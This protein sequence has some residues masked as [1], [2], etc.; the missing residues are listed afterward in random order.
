MSDSAANGRE[1]G[2]LP[3]G[4]PEIPNY[5]LV[6]LIAR[7]SYGEVW[8]ARDLI[9]TYRAVKIVYRSTFPDERPFKR[10]FEG[11][12]KFDPVSRK[13]PGLVDIL[14]VGEIGESEGFYYVMELAD[15]CGKDATLA[16]TPASDRVPFAP[17]N[18]RPKSLRAVLYSNTNG[19]NASRRALPLSE[20]LTIA[21]ELAS[22][23]DYLHQ[24]KLVHRDVKPSNIIFIDG[25]PKLADIGL[26]AKAGEQCSFVGTE[27]FVPR[28][29][30]GNPQADLFALGK[31][32]YEM[33]TGFSAKECPRVPD[34]WSAAPNREQLQAANELVMRAC[35]GN[36]KRR[37]ESA[38]EMH[39]DLDLLLTGKTLIIRK[40][41]RKLRRV[42][43]ALV[44]VAAA[45]VLAFS[46]S[47]S[48]V[49]KNRAAEQAR[50]RTLRELQISHLNLQNGGWFSTEWPLLENAAK[51]QKDTEV[52]GQAFASLAGWD[53]K[54][55]RE[56]D[57]LTAE[58]ASFGPRGE[59]LVISTETGKSLIMGQR[60]ETTPLPNVG[61]GPATWVSD[62]DP[63][64]LVPGAGE[65]LLLNPLNGKVKTRL[66]I[67]STLGVFTSN[68]VL[69]LSSNGDLAAAAEHGQIL[70]WQTKNG[71][72]S[73]SMHLDA[74]ALAFAPDGSLLSAGN[75]NGETRIFT[76]RDL[77]EIAVL[78]PAVRGSPITCLAF[79]RDPLIRYGNTEATNSWLLVVGD[80]GAEIVIWD[81]EKRIPRSFCRGSTW[82]VA[83][84]AFSP[85]GFTLGSA[86]RNEPRLWDYTTGQ[87]LLALPA[88]GSGA[89]TVLSF[90]RDG[91]EIAYG[92]LPG[93]GRSG[94][95]IT[96]LQP[97]R[98]VH[99]LRGLSSPVRKL[100]FSN[101][102]RTITG[103]SD[104]WQLGVWDVS[105]CRLRY[106]FET[107][108]GSLADSAGGHFDRTGQR[109]AF[110]AGHEARLYDLTSGLLL[111]HWG[112]EHGR[113]DAIQWDDR[114]RLLLLRWERLSNEPNGCR[115]VYQLAESAKP[116]L[117]IEQP[118]TNWTLHDLA[119]AEGGRT[120]L[121]WSEGPEKAPRTIHAYSTD[122]GKELWSTS[123]ARNESNVGVFLDPTGSCFAYTA[124]SARKKIGSRGVP[125][126]HRW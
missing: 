39:A 32:L 48:W 83:S 82:T 19:G 62:R 63:D 71:V 46:I 119:F 51:V 98:G 112:L 64:L 80:Q 109:F 103:L 3:R 110:S 7:G 78:P 13:H 29:G 115:R 79:A 122:D 1:E 76:T 114:G 22:A 25:V 15:D 40:L 41:Q 54:R 75:A 93:E 4:T 44:G 87:P 56:L 53:A 55:I 33:L 30:P 101:D 61:R 94:F 68:A 108:V 58:S 72:V 59:V 9:G 34:D 105:P 27:E 38:A 70:T 24:H 8:L 49:F 116:A 90:S 57:D 23:L 42:K 106:V 102:G 73:E 85:D 126:L 36:W 11:I 118:Q 26:V 28:E 69:A 47:G 97:D 123:T 121:A 17:E 16:S 120:Y 74:T 20:C 117:L 31:V 125:F 14:H 113:S 66:P 67:P 104:N 81:I 21:R 77:K 107:P 43:W 89:T 18:Y 86:G 5:K 88:V 84:L 60:G 10:E 37:Y 124:V 65:L 96:A 91:Q 2:R 35:E 52:A 95:M 6:R 12:H 50:R 45:S 100:W 111:S 99:T 92:S